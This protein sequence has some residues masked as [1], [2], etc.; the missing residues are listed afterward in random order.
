MMTRGLCYKVGHN[1]NFTAAP[2]YYSA[3]DIGIFSDSNK[4][5]HFVKHSVKFGNGTKII[6]IDYFRGGA[7]SFNLISS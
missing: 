6:I 1:D 3:H 7:S 4:F 2:I 5:S